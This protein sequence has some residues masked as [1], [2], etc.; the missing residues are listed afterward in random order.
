[1]KKANVKN[2]LNEISADTRNYVQLDSQEI[3]FRKQVT[4]RTFVMDHSIE[5]TTTYN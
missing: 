1:M 4:D 2:A 5:N 3:S